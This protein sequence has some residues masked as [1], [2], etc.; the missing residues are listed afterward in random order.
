MTTPRPTAATGGT[1]RANKM[2]VPIAGVKPFPSVKDRLNCITQRG[3]TNKSI[4]LIL[5]TSIRVV[6]N[7]TRNWGRIWAALG[8]DTNHEDSARQT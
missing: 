4:A 2:A 3:I 7:L 8:T 6:L 1:T 5:V